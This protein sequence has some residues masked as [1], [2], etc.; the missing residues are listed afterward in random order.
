M[1]KACSF[2]QSHHLTFPPYSFST[3]CK[4]LEDMKTEKSATLPSCHQLCEP[5][6]LWES[7][8]TPT[9]FITFAATFVK[10]KFW[11]YLLAIFN[12]VYRGGCG[13]F[14]FFFLLVFAH[15]WIRSVRVFG[16]MGFLVLIFCLFVFE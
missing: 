10:M 12:L 8:W 1:L 15:C 11:L 6:T 5:V 3:W 2:L 9:N 7:P 4:T 16:L 14:F 13:F